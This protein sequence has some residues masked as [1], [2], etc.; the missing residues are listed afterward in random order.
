MLTP[1]FSYSL[2]LNNID[3]LSMTKTAYGATKIAPLVAEVVY[4][5]Q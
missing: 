2:K 3:E 4:L 1:I 5:I